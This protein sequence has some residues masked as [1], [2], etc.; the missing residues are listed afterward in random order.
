ME[1]ELQFAAV[2][3]DNPGTSNPNA[4]I[5]GTSKNNASNPSASNPDASDPDASDPVE[6]EANN[7][8]TNEAD[9]DGRMPG[10]LSTVADIDT[11]IGSICT[12]N[13][14]GLHGHKGI[15]KSNSITVFSPRNLL[16]IPL[17]KLLAGFTLC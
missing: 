17:R 2:K 12:T 4:S 1:L 8:T 15:F 16:K 14:V 6:E 11:W 7:N 10:Q 13:E 9:A 5:P 3:E